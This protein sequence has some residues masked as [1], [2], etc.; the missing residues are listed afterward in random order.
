MSWGWNPTTP[1]W[2][3]FLFR[4]GTKL[5]YNEKWGC[6]IL[7]RPKHTTPCLV[8]SLFLFL[9]LGSDTFA[10]PVKSGWSKFSPQFHFATT[11]QFYDYETAVSCNLPMLFFPS[12]KSSIGVINAHLD[13]RLIPEMSVIMITESVLIYTLYLIDLS[14]HF[15]ITLLRNLL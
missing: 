1:Q 5:P 6:L 7:W 3:R 8:K 12:T 2:S 4:A 11:L 9:D 14:N 15:T 13:T 10:V